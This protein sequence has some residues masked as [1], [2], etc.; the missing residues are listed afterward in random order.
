M[1]LE[2]TGKKYGISG[3][4]LEVY[5]SSGLAGAK[6]LTETGFYTETDL[7]ALGLIDML[8]RAGFDQEEAKRYLIMGERPD[9]GGAAA[10]QIRM[11]REHRS[12]LRDQIHE[13]Q[14]LLDSLD[15][16]I[17]NKKKQEEAK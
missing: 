12:C 7:A 14:K 13:K 9:T 15:F 8:L 4:P 10:S 2:E 1:T 6:A 3:D 16:M 5:L 17:W 11:L